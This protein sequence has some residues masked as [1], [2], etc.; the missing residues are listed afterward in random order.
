M[1]KRIS[2]YLNRFQGVFSS[3]RAKNVYKYVSTPGWDD[4]KLIMGFS[5][6]IFIPKA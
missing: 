5:V 1:T 4:G 6:N 3:R 2:T